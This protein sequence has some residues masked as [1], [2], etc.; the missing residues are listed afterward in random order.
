VT[1][2][3]QTNGVVATPPA[4]V[5]DNPLAI[6]HMALQG[7]A[8]P[9]KLEKLMDLAERFKSDRAAEAFA[10][11]M[12]SVQNEMPCV[13]KDRENSHTRARY[14]TLENVQTVIRPVYA[15][16]GFSL[17]Y[18]TEESKLPG[19]VRLVCDVSHTGGCTRRYHLDC[20]M[21]GAG[22]KGGSNKTDI[23]AM[24]SS[25]SYG[26]RYLVLMIFNITVANQDVDGNAAD[27]LDTITE[28]ECLD[29][30]GLMEDKKVDYARFLEWCR[31]AGM[32][33]ANAD[34]LV[35][36]IGKKHLA[37]VLDIL[38]RKAAPK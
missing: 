5:A 37:K 3:A 35:K 33:V 19:H 30:E 22:A 38:N 11:A 18:G 26:R 2:L 21:D 20:P 34:P 14:A 17:S 24:G 13:V 29:I 23:Q 7:G 28:A 25:I 36:N 6:L 4:P 10:V 8:D 32:F 15:R 16:H 27:A 1:A 31:T 9:A 12:N